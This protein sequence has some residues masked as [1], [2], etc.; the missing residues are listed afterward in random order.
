[1]RSRDNEK[2][3]S[4]VCFTTTKK[5]MPYIFEMTSTLLFFFSFWQL[6][7]ILSTSSFTT[8]GLPT[9]PFYSTLKHLL[10]CSDAALKLA[11]KLFCYHFYVQVELKFNMHLL[12][13]LFLK[14]PHDLGC[15]ISTLVELYCF[16]P[17]ICHLWKLVCRLRD[18]VNLILTR[19]SNVKGSSALTDIW[20]KSYG[21]LHMDRR[22]K[23]MQ[24]EIHM[25]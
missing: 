25:V 5:A 8:F 23:K 3:S 18:V 14:L 15:M 24:K 22:R 21:V 6:G 4:H 20:R 9:L 13:F 2:C 16:A 7:M 19:W 17:T 12:L 11:S 1:M 10:C